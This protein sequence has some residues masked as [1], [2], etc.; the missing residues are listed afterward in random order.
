MVAAGDGVAQDRLGMWERVS[1]RRREIAWG[2]AAA[3]VLAAAGG[4]TASPALRAR[5]SAGYQAFRDPSVVGARAAECP[6]ESSLAIGL[7]QPEIGDLDEATP[8]EIDGGTA[9]LA[10][11]T[12]SDLPVP[13]SKRTMHFVE[14]F[15]G[16]EKGRKAFAERFR[17][18]GRYREHI[19]RALRDAR[20]PE[21]LLWL[22]AI[23]S[24][25]N[26]QAISP[27]GAAGLFQFMPETAARYGLAVNEVVDERRSITKSTAAGVAHLSDL[28]EVYGSWE[29]ALAAF[30]LGRER[31][32]DAIE[33]LKVMRPARER[34]KPA[35]LKELAEARLIPKE[36]ANFVPQIQ[37]FA[38]VAANRGS[39]GLDELDPAAPLDFA[40]LAVPPGT[41][42]RTVA[43]AAGISVATLRDHN[44]DFLGERVPADGG[45]VLVNVPSD[46]V[47]QA[48]SSF[49]TYA[50]RDQEEDAADAG[51]DAAAA[52]ASAAP[53]APKAERWTLASGIAVEKQP[54]AGADVQLDARVEL[55]DPTRNGFR[56][57]GRSFSAP[58]V[59]APARAFDGALRQAAD[60]IR[61]LVEDRGEAGA[62]L[63]KR[64]A[65][66]RRETL[67]KTPYGVG[68]IA[69]AEALFP[70]G[71][72]SA[73]AL[74]SGLP[75]PG[76][77]VL[78]AEHEPRGAIRVALSIRGD[79]DRKLA[80]PAI[81]RAF[82]DLA[83][84]A[85]TP[86]PPHPRAERRAVTDDVQSPR[87]L[88]GWIGPPADDATDGATRLA[89]TLLAHG[90]M[91]RATRAM[92]LERRLAARV[93]GV[94]ELGPRGSV[95]TIEAVP[96]VPHDVGEV[97]AALDEVIA[98]LAAEGPTAP[99]LSAAK[100]LTR[101]RLE[102]ERLIA[103]TSAGPREA[104]IAAATRA[105]EA[106][107]AASADDVQAAA[108]KVFTR[109]HRV[110]VTIA[111][112]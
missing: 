108:R 81:A 52:S 58:P 18:A 112:R 69:L 101:A 104:R 28:Y 8:A 56:A 43:G 60:R 109:D 73:G 42:L 107:E 10:T 102:R 53:A 88:L 4:V 97:E 76:A 63:R 110:I 29:L 34:G 87:L 67:E 45:D 41:R 22:V 78:F 24:G 27:K 105:L 86:W 32:D 72:P 55:Y 90:S 89:L 77:E 30:N 100:A 20:L 9:A 48:L 23:E 65:E 91:G 111:P 40:E 93:R 98:K 19:E 92:V 3:A 103:A 26:P 1:R 62:E 17:R 38:I 35:T 57:A 75:Q 37:A 99:V 95:A 59:T 51:A 94:L 47:A 13:V 85:G 12:L 96:A 79:V 11:L 25:F 74:L 44:P 39:F 21:D 66:R 64:L 54:A 50:Q 2:A 84:G 68:W 6:D 14:Y 33:K 61:A 15:A 70:P 31:L 36:T 106:V 71:H 16:D 5:L 49:A 80:E 82:G 83:P 7:E 46:R